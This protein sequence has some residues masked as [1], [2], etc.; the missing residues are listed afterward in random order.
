MKPKSDQ[1]AERKCRDKMGSCICKDK[2]NNALESSSGAHGHSGASV[3][4]GYPT[5]SVRSDAASSSSSGYHGS[6]GLVGRSSSKKTV[7]KALVLETL[8]VIRTLIDK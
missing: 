1:R 6:Q 2:S 4:G 7:V 3:E 5:D 8:S